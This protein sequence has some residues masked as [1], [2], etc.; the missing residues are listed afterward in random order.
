MQIIIA[1]NSK[2]NILNRLLLVRKKVL[3]IF[4]IVFFLFSVIGVI[5][6]SQKS[7]EE[8]FSPSPAPSPTEYLSPPS[9]LPIKDYEQ[10]LNKDVKD[11]HWINN[12]ELGYT[13]FEVKRKKRVLAKT[14]GEKETILLSDPEIK[15][16]E[17]YWSGKNDV[18]IFDYGNPYKTYLLSN[19]YSLRDLNIKGY[20]FSWSP[21][22][23]S[24][25]YTEESDD[26]LTPKIYNLAN[27]SFS[28]ID[29]NLP[30]FHVSFWSPKGDSVLLYKYDLELTNS[31]LYLFNLE[32]NSV[33]EIK[34]GN[35]TFPTWSPSGEAIGYISS[36]SLFIFKNGVDKIIYKPKSSYFSYGWLDEDK[37]LIFD[38][39]K[40]SLSAQVIY[41]KTNQVLQIFNQ[42]NFLPDQLIKIA[43]SSD[44]AKIA[45]AT[46]KN[47][48]W[49][50]RSPF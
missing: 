42:L 25:F 14:E 40:E 5:L 27:N 31:I 23:S 39:T 11:I 29:K 13:F 36:D 3:I 48:L 45:L 12:Q 24:F 38:S 28:V 33:S 46:E 17:I 32:N 6:F 19:L 22:G 49:V 35:I 8:S 34:R 16:S 10:V 15:M 7:K 50:I 1:D 20:G 18:L 21:N 4:L 26:Y 30:L 9:T 41:L 37:I 2:M 44:T 47:G 43:V